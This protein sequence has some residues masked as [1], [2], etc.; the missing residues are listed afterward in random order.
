MLPILPFLLQMSRNS[1]I[2]PLP[3]TPVGWKV[4]PRTGLDESTVQVVEYDFD[5]LDPV[6]ISVPD[7]VGAIIGL[8]G[9]GRRCWYRFRLDGDGGW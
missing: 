6:A 5:F 2:P 4:G 7:T 8:S 3:I 1:G 9:D